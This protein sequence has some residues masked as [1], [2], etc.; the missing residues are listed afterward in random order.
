[1]KRQ[2]VTH[3]QKGISLIKCFNNH[4]LPSSKSSSVMANPFGVLIFES[5]KDFWYS[6]ASFSRA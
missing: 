4:D 3:D 2:Q 5:R 6:A 1:M